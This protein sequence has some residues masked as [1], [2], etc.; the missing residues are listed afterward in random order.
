MINIMK[1]G[2]RQTRPNKKLS[3]G[4]GLEQGVPSAAKTIKA[5]VEL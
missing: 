3:H 1:Q 5:P 2:L 4:A